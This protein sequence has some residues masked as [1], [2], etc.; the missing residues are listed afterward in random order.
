MKQIIKSII[1]ITCCSYTMMILF[2]ILSTDV[3]A[4][5]INRTSLWQTFLICFGCAITVQF[6][7]IIE[8]KNQ[9]MHHIISYLSIVCCVFGIG[10]FVLRLIPFDFIVYAAISMFTLCI[11]M[12]CWF[13]YFKKNKSDADFINEQLQERR[14]ERM[15]E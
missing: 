5:D 4:P 7:G 2:F 9:W 3:I 13:L 15:H 11:Y 12:V 14:K 1:T 10:S 6:I 8:M